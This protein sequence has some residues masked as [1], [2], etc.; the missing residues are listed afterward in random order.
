MPSRLLQQ[1]QAQRRSLAEV[2]RRLPCVQGWRRHPSSESF[3]HHRG[4]RCSPEMPPRMALLAPRER[5]L[6]FRSAGCSSAPAPMDIASGGHCRRG[7]LATFPRP[8]SSGLDLWPAAHGAA[9]LRGRRWSRASPVRPAPR[10]HEGP[11]SGPKPPAG[12]LPL[13]AP[14]RSVPT[15]AGAPPPRSRCLRGRA[16]RFAEKPMLHTRTSLCRPSSY[17]CA[18]TFLR[19]CSPPPCILQVCSSSSTLRQHRDS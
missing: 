12:L 7:F 16:L 8:A 10:P 18:S 11:P 15:V 4:L 19:N 13:G 14:L 3:S 6:S 2:R 17:S 5:A 9:A 1:T